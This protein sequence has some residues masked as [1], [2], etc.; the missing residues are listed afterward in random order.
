MEI[1]KLKE[2]EERI[3]KR[4]DMEAAFRFMLDDA[5]SKTLKLD[6]DVS[7]PSLG[8]NVKRGGLY[9]H[10]LFKGY[11]LKAILTHLP[12]LVKDA[13]S[14]EEEDFEH[15]KEEATNEAIAVIKGDV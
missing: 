5:K 10:S 1:K 12:E 7:N 13:L 9:I 6:I 8:Q 15:L 11:L 4:E 3:N 14:F 2:L